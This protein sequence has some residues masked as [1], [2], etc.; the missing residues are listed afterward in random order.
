[1]SRAG[2]VRER[3]RLEAV[4][5]KPE[6]AGARCCAWPGCEAEGTHRAP[7]ARDR[8]RE[9]QYLCLDHVREFNQR[10]DYF[11]GMSADEIHAHQ[12][13]DTTWHR[14]TWRFGTAP[15][16]EPC[17]RDVFGLFT[18]GPAK[19]RRQGPPPRPQR[20]PTKAELMMAVLELEDGF[21]LSELK[22]RYKTLAKR[23]HPDL[24][25]GDK[26]AEERLKQ[27]IEA[28]TYLREQRLYA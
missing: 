9:F 4:R 22:T 5:L 6:E 2:R 1:M 24:H 3:E 11:A 28:Y 23:H 25:G 17:W 7:L 21:T 12:R 13:A 20:P 14:P 19:P 8:L 15:G 27:V 26:A 16:A 18:D 10:W